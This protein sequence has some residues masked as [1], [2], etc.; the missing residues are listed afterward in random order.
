VYLLRQRE[1]HLALVPPHDIQKKHWFAH[2]NLP[3]EL[4]IVWIGPFLYYQVS[5]L[6]TVKRLALCS[7][8]FG[9]PALFLLSEIITKAPDIKLFYSSMTSNEPEVPE[10]RPLSHHH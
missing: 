7:F 2:E 5:K 4:Y 1:A 10:K 6:I 9:F 8:F 3:L